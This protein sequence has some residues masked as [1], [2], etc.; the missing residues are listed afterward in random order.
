MEVIFIKDLRNQGKKGEIKNVKDGYAINFLIKNGYAVK[1]N[2]DSLKNLEKN[3]QKELELDEKNKSDALMLKEKLEKE[4]LTFKVRTG[5]KDKVFGSVSTK[6]IKEK[7]ANYKID[8]SDIII[9]SPISSLGY[10]EIEIILYKN[11]KAK[12]KVELVK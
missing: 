8:K 10:H 7:L 6:Q 3:K 4:T 1:K 12:V 9:K 11:I 2:E 5:D